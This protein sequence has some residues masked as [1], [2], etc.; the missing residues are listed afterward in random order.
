[1]NNGKEQIADDC[2]FLVC[3]QEESPGTQFLTQKVTLQVGISKSSV[4]HILKKRKVKAFKRVSTPQ[5]NDS[6][7][8]KRTKRLNHFCNVLVIAV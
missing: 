1:M 8:H 6:C 5:M 4:H 3:S 2:E 7:C